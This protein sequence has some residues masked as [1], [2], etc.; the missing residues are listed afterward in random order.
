[1]SLHR[2]CP[3]DTDHTFIH[4]QQSECWTVRYMLRNEGFLKAI[5]FSNQ[6]HTVIERLM[7]AE[8]NGET[9]QSKPPVVFLTA[10]AFASV[11]IFIHPDGRAGVPSYALLTAVK[12]SNWPA[13]KAGDLFDY[14]EETYFRAQYLNRIYGRALNNTVR[15]AILPILRALRQQ[16]ENLTVH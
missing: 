2:S 9:A 10:P 13:P 1:M 6:V 5:S 8:A 14:G 12:K 4:P 16:E 11:P 3:I 15:Q 7:R